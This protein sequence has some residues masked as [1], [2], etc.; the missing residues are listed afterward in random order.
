MCPS[1]PLGQGAACNVC[2]EGL[3]G[4]FILPRCHLQVG[5]FIVFLPL[6]A[7]WV[8]LWEQVTYLISEASPP[9]GGTSKLAREVLVPYAW[10]LDFEFRMVPGGEFDIVSLREGKCP[11]TCA[12][13]GTACMVYSIQMVVDYVLIHQ[14]LWYPSL[15]GLSLWWEGF[16]S[17]SF[18]IQCD[19]L[20][21]FDQWH[22]CVRGDR[23]RFWAEGLRTPVFTFPSAMTTGDI[24]DRSCFSSLGPGV[25]MMQKRPTANP[26]R[27][28]HIKKLKFCCC[29]TLHANTNEEGLGTLTTLSSLGS[30]LHDDYQLQKNT[31]FWLPNFTV[32]SEE[33]R[34]P[35]H[36]SMPAINSRFWRAS[37]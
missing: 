25:R 10:I 8:C 37:W 35:S 14:I 28:Q 6:I 36:F 9:K 32:L 13:K 16:T 30:L 12:G 22:V 33:D 19:H 5:V 24:L 31:A 2:L 1:P 23:S 15:Q 4:L 34:V 18:G 7:Y 11:L 3:E 21:C 17:W 26:Q 20:I 27:M 29:K